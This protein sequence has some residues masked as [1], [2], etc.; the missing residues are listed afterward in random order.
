M[1]S[2]LAHLLEWMMDRNECTTLAKDLME[3][4][5][6]V[7]PNVTLVR[8]NGYPNKLL[9]YFQQFKKISWCVKLNHNFNIIY[10]LDEVKGEPSRVDHEFDPSCVA[11]HL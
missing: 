4:Q 6:L 10:N 11:I 2:S 1:F 5:R 9:L 3:A 8:H 7:L